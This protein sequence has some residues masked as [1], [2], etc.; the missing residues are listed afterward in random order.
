MVRAKV[1]LV[2]TNDLFFSLIFNSNYVM[3]YG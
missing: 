2:F 3:L 1:D